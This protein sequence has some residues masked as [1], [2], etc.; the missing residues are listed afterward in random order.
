M[1]EREQA[2]YDATDNGFDI[3]TMLYPEAAEC[4]NNPN[5]KFK[6]RDERTPSTGCKQNEKGIWYANDFGGGG[7]EPI[8]LYIEKNHV[9][10]TQALEELEAHFHINGKESF[11][12]KP[13][14]EVSTVQEDTAG[15]GF[16]FEAKESFTNSELNLLAPGLTEEVCERYSYKSLKSYSFIY[17]DK[18]TGEKKRMKKSSTDNYPIFM[19]DCGDF[20]K[21]YEPY[22][23]DKNNRFQYRPR[24][25]K[26]KDYVN[27]LAEL[28]AAFK[29]LSQSG[30][31]AA[32]QED[33]AEGSNQQNRLPRKLEAAFLCSGERDALCVAAM[34][35]NPIWLNSESAKLTGE[36][37]AEIMKCVERL[38]NIPDIDET[39]IRQG[40]KLALKYLDIYT[41]ELPDELRRQHD[42]RG[43]PCKDLRDYLEYNSAKDFNRLVNVAMPCKFWDLKRS[44]QDKINTSYLLHILNY[45]GYGKIKLQTKPGAISYLYV[46]VTNNEVEEVSE[47]EVADNLHRWAMERGLES[48]IR[49]AI[50]DCK[51]IQSDLLDKLNEIKVPF[52]N[53]TETEQIFTFENCSVKVSAD[54]VKTMAK[55]EAG[56]I[57]KDKVC[58]HRFTRIEPAFET[59]Y[60]SERKKF[61]IEIKNIKSHGFRANINSSRIHWRKEL[62]GGEKEPADGGFVDEDYKEKHKWDIAGTRLGTA[63]Q[64]EQKQTLINRLY[65][66]GY[67]LHSYKSPTNGYIT[68]LMENKLTDESESS[69]GSGKSFLVDFL[70]KPLINKEQADGSCEAGNPS[71]KHFGSNVTTRTTTFVIADANRGYPIRPLFEKTTG[72]WMARPLYKDPYTI[73]FEQSPKIVV[74]SN[75]PPRTTEGSTLRRLLFCIF[76]DYYHAGTSEYN[77]ERKINHDFGYR[78]CDENDKRY[79][80]EYWNEDLNF[81]MDCVSFYLKAEKEGVVIQP[82][83]ERI[84]ERIA[85]QVAGDNFMMWAEAKFAKES[86]NLNTYLIREDLLDEY[87]KQAAKK[88]DTRGFMEKLRYFCQSKEY[89]E[90]INPRECTGY[91]EYRRSIQIKVNKEVKEM[92]YIQSKGAEVKDYEREQITY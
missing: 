18:E 57:W 88:I 47:K 61:D 4:K 87:N 90:K 55:E 25:K 44:K 32:E 40:R 53:G 16:E 22:S 5:H 79:T 56:Y 80:D 1:N 35:Y 86:D 7:G 69:G 8:K 13:N 74:T 31:E 38:Y 42:R 36:Q 21:I 71:G 62:E 82:P 48:E 85:I 9:E 54:N 70:L 75:F 29:A 60:D 37:Y 49:N 50:L 14:I 52:K 12:R 64:E 39:G 17:T 92:V 73:P 15:D 30:S 26:T 19:H 11:D 6:I 27:G 66:I 67:L 78:I 89:I 91:R 51:K 84:K 83:M 43:N 10:Y 76:S 41:V 45:M 2:I 28:K 58:H 34:G 72:D 63:E 46:K 33:H 81:L 77:E 3:I 24:D 20:Y 65:V 59:K 68:W 23:K